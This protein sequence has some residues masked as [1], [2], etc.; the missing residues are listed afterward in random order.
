MIIKKF[1][2]IELLAVIAVLLLVTTIVTLKVGRFPSFVALEKEVQSVQLIF[3]KAARQAAI[4][5]KVIKVKYL[6]DSKQFEIL[7]NNSDQTKIK[8]KVSSSIEIEILEEEIPSEIY[9]QF[10]PDGSA[11]G[12]DI[13]FKQNDQALKLSISPLTGVSYIEEIEE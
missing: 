13:K 7:T 8:Y 6:E 2:L 9:F 5:G 1:S 3:A 11:S 12:I 10:F 4:Q